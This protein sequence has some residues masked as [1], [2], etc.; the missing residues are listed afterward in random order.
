M[1]DSQ[2]DYE[3]T[4]NLTLGGMTMNLGGLTSGSGLPSMGAYGGSSHAATTQFVYK[5]VTGISL[6]S[7]VNITSEDIEVKGR[8]LMKL[9]DKISDRLAILDD[10]S[11]ARLEKFAALRDAYERYKTLEALIGDGLPKKE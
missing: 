9:L 4:G 5:G 10:P 1:S 2:F 7:S 3:A 8:S 11:E 6:S